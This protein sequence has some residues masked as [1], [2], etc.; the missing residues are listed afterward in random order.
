MFVVK[1]CNDPEPSEANFHAIAQ[2][3]K[4]VAQNIHLMMLASFFFTYEEVFTVNSP[5]KTQISEC[6]RTSVS[7]INQEVFLP[8][9]AMLARY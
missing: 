4:T 5:K 9:D 1:Y 7:S 6:I 3:F 8:R 2:S